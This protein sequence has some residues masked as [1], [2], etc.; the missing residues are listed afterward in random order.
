M[1]RKLL[2]MAITGVV[3]LLTVSIVGCTSTPSPTSAPV[4]TPAPPTTKP[5]PPTTKPT[6]PTT[7]PAPTPAVTPKPAVSVKYIGSTESDKYHYPSCRYAEKIK[8]EN[9]IEFNSV[10]EAQAA[11]YVPCGVCKPP[12]KD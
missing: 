4:Q 11:G 3:L 8:P 5:A 10:A 6:P 9:R 2:S 1:K 12:T 7:E